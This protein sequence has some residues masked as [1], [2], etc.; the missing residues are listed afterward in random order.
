[1]REPEVTQLYRESWILKQLYD[2]NSIYLETKGDLGPFVKLYNLSRAAGLS[3]E[4]VVRILKIADDDLLRLEGRC[5]NLKSQV[6]SLEAK[7]ENLI[8][9]MHE[10]E[11]QVGVL[12]R[13][14]DNYCRLCTEEELKLTDLQ[15]KRMKAETLVS[16]L[17]NNDKGCPRIGKVVEEK[18]NS[19]LSNGMMLLKLAVYC[20]LQ[21][22]KMN[23]KQSVSLTYDSFSSSN[24]NLSAYPD[25]INDL[26]IASES[27]LVNSVA[28][29]YDTLAKNLV[30]EILS[31][32][33]VSSLQPSLPSE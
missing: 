32:Y 28:K 4:H 20:V 27:I 19:V 12:G 10:Y 30:D 22:I 21:S 23:P 5:Y 16:Y 9:I 3:A 1:M 17:E 14:F 7:K 26:T 2:L 11:N 29:V 15:R 18:V 6:R 31:K 8:R 24:Y 33:E 13:S 25:N